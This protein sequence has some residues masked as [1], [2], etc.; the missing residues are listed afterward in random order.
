MYLNLLA[1]SYSDNNK[2]TDIN[3]DNN[4]V[5]SEDDT[6]INK[7]GESVTGNLEIATTHDEKTKNQIFK[8]NYIVL[9]VVIFCGS[10]LIV[11]VLKQKKHKF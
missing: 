4:S 5:E 1:N 2:K 6:I 10:I 9:F 11:V 7:S 8:I 3:N